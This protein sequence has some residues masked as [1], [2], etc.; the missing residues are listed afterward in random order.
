MKRKSVDRTYL[1]RV[2]DRS[3]K[4]IEVNEEDFKGY[5]SLFRM[6]EVRD[7][8][9]FK[10]GEK[11][12]C[13]ID[14][15]YSHLQYVPFNCDY[16][17]TAF[18][19]DNGEIV[20]WYFDIISGCG[21]DE[22]GVPFYDDMY[23]DVILLPNSEFYLVDEDELKEALDEGKITKAQFD[24]AYKAAY[25]LVDEI[26]KGKA[27]LIHRCKSDFEKMLKLLD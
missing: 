24:R 6:N 3:F 10:Y 27:P 2:L 16:A 1:S 13:V 4:A 22:T 14:K 19:N 20:Q 5:L 18:V 23:L 26:K 15:G 17:L 12:I 11:T 8:R 21:T 7:S 9:S 25:E